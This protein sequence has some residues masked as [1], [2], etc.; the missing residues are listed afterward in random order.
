M[1]PGPS[2]RV[3]EAGAAGSQAPCP[4]MLARRL[5]SG[6]YRAA[7]VG[8]MEVHG[9]R[10]QKSPRSGFP[11]TLACALWPQWHYPPGPG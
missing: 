6:G 8:G 9:T 10:G 3:Q 1:L 5:G 7:R 4:G 2:L 11:G